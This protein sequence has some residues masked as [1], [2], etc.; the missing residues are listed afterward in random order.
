MAE[1][2]K[3]KHP[4]LS[5]M[6]VASHSIRDSG[7]FGGSQGFA[8]ALGQLH[9]DLILMTGYRID[10]MYDKGKFRHEHLL[11]EYGHVGP[12]VGYAD[13]FSALCCASGP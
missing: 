7:Y 12:V 1:T 3:G 5:S 2:R 10:R 11:Y 13:A 4:H 6:F 9:I 8:K